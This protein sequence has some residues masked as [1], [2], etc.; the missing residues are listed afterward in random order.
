[1]QHEEQEGEKPFWEKDI[2][3]Q[4]IMRL[5]SRRPFSSSTGF[6]GLCS[7]HAR[8]TDEICLFFGGGLAYVV[9]SQDEGETYTLI[10]EA[11][12]HGIM[13]GEL[14][15]GDYQEKEFLLR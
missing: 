9:R 1:M 8:P 6:V 13:Y 11:Y 4:R 14:L 3:I 15:R 12:V 2:Y 10:G 7:M 5:H